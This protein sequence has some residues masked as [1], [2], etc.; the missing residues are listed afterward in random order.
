R[1]AGALE[2]TTMGHGWKSDVDAM[3]W[4]GHAALRPPLSARTIGTAPERS[5]GRRGPRDRDQGRQAM[6]PAP[7]STTVDAWLAWFATHK[8][9]ACRA[10]LCARYHLDALDA[11]ALMNTA[12]L[13]VFLHWETVEHPLA[14]FWQTLTHAVGKQ[15]QR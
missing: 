6:S 9:A 7:A 4:R 3:A 13:Q 10:F 8:Q 14:Y 5:P 15:G 12:R 2:G 11:E 1:S